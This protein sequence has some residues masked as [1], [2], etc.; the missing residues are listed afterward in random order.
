MTQE[1]RSGDRVRLRAPSPLLALRSNLGHVVTPHREEGYWIV[2]L[3]APADYR[4]ADGQTRHL[5]RIVE[6][7]DNLAILERPS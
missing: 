7:A 3:D 1:I 6:H 5:L 4:D 2:E